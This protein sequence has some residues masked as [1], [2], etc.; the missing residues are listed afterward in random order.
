MIIECPHCATRFRLEARQL[1]GGRSMLKCARCRRVFPAPGQAPSP[2]RA[3]RSAADDNMSFAF[4]D[5]DEWRA[6]EL[7]SEDVPE[8]AFLLNDPAAPTPA[9]TQAHLAATAGDDDVIAI[10]TCPVRSQ[11]PAIER[12]IF[13]AS[14]WF[15]VTKPPSASQQLA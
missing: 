3:K 4:D 13:V 5:D 15:A 7:T 6:P 12:V 10:P 2:R 14:W 8:D 9:R 1:S 11:R